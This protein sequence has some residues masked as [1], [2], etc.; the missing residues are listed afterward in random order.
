MDLP[1]RNAEYDLRPGPC[2]S[3]NP[4]RLHFGAL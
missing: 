1:E 3:A 2:G 4:R